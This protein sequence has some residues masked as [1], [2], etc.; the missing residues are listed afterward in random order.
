[1]VWCKKKYLKKKVNSVFKPQQAILAFFF[2][3]V[4]VKKN[5]TGYTN[6]Y[7]CFFNRCPIN[8]QNCPFTPRGAQAGSYTF[9]MLKGLCAVQ[10]TSYAPHS[11]TTSKSM[12]GTLKVCC[13]LFVIRWKSLAW[14][15][16]EPAVTRW[17][18]T[19]GYWDKNLYS[20]EWLLEDEQLM[21]MYHVWLLGSG[22]G[23]P[24]SDVGCFCVYSHR[25]APDWMRDKPQRYL[26]LPHGKSGSRV[27][28]TVLPARQRILSAWTG[29]KI[30]CRSAIIA[31][32]LPP[33]GGR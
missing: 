10:A 11:A 22:L 28:H 33:F 30:I 16:I 6:R 24:I 4:F 8:Y 23:D 27:V 1:M 25:I 17:L 32:S 3:T 20:P 31:R 13:S 2:K 19:K 5:E 18:T 26:S 9:L 14:V 15:R 21:M 7:S 29:Q 12:V